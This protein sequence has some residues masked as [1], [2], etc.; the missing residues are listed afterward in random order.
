VKHPNL[1]TLQIILTIAIFVL[2]ALY[3]IQ[4]ASAQVSSNAIVQ[5]EPSRTTARIGETFTVN[6]TIANVQNLYGVDVTLD[7]NNSILQILRNESRLGVESNPDGVL[8]SPISIIDESASQEIGEYHLVATSENPADS[9]N[10]NGTIATLTFNVTNEGH[11][12]LD[13]QSELADH[14]S[15]SEQSNFISHTDASGSVDT[16][17]PE[18]PSLVSIVLILVAA[19]TA[20]LVSKKLLKKS[21]APATTNSNTLKI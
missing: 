2:L 9:F 19:T 15:P 12:E 1:S 8:H 10:G 14:P 6:I 17:I 20:F 21:A 7:W 16:V 4:A 18:F 13:L 3:P 5:V 11:S